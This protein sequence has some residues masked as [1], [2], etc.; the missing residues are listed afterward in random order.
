MKS[1]LLILI[2]LTS[3]VSF[4]QTI[5]L[6]READFPNDKFITKKEQQT[7]GTITVDIVQVKPNKQGDSKQFACRTWLTIK[8][9][10]KII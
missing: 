5:A 6:Y 8:E 10:N 4:G 7:L 1:R 9:K 3:Y 2:I